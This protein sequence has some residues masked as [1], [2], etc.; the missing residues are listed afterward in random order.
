MKLEVV[1]RRNPKNKEGQ[2]HSQRTCGNDQKYPKSDAAA[3]GRG[4]LTQQ[5][6]IK[7]DLTQRV[8]PAGRC[9]P[10]VELLPIQREMGKSGGGQEAREF[11]PSRSYVVENAS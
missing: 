5:V 3:G 2:D 9:S 1:A 6:W 7:T 11:D 8:S 10:A 4:G